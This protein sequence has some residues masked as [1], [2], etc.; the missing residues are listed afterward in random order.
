[1]GSLE[2]AWVGQL[3]QGGASCGITRA[4]RA[5]DQQLS[6]RSTGHMWHPAQVLSG[7]EQARPSIATCPRH[8]D[9]RAL[10]PCQRCGDY[11]CLNCVK[12]DSRGSAYCPM[13]APADPLPLA[14]LSS[15]MLGHAVDV[16]LLYGGSMARGR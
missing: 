16:L 2:I 6:R 10:E 4:L 3:A 1:M 13:C 14:S 8:P 5:G 12:H 9:E 7:P 11:V 15:R